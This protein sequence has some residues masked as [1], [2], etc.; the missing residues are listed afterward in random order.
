MSAPADLS[1]RRLR[2]IA[3]L[4]EGVDGDVFKG[5]VEGPLGL[6]RLVLVKRSRRL[7]DFDEEPVEALGREARVYARLDHPCI[8]RLVDFYVDHGRLLLLTTWVE[9]VS[10]EALLEEARA[11]GAPLPR[12]AA[13]HVAAQL[14]SAL[15]AAHGA[16]DPVTREFSP[17]V[18]Q[19][20]SPRTVTVTRDGGVVLGDFERS[21]TLASQELTPSGLLGTHEGYLA[22]EQVQGER[23]SVRADVY[24]ACIVLREM[25]LN[26]PT[27]PH[28]DKDYLEWLDG[29]A[30]PRLRPIR[31]LLPDL[32]ADIAWL[33]DVGLR[34]EPEQRALTASIAA[35]ILAPYGE[36]SA[37]AAR[38]RLHHQA[39]PSSPTDPDRTASHQSLVAARPAPA[40]EVVPPVPPPAP[41]ATST[42]I[43]VTARP[44][45]G[46]TVQGFA[47]R[48]IA[49]RPPRGPRH[50]PAIA[51]TAVLALA[52]GGAAFVIARRPAAV[53]TSGTVASLRPAAAVLGS[54]KVAS[55]SSA[56]A[57]PVVP[58]AA[59]V[60]RLVLGDGHVASVAE[61]LALA[62]ASGLEGR[63]A[64]CFGPE[65]APHN[66]LTLRARCR[67]GA[68]LTVLVVAPIT[69]P[70]RKLAA[71]TEV[72]LDQR[73]WG[74]DPRAF[75][76]SFDTDR[77]F[78]VRHVGTA[79]DNRNPILGPSFGA[80][81]DLGIEPELTRAMAGP[82][83][84]FRVED[85][86]SSVGRFGHVR[87]E[88][89]EVFRRVP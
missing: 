65:D 27:F 56:A 1:R 29:I 59:P 72:P 26:A 16:C 19:S 54:S 71:F 21:R 83:S 66:G 79:V 30:H 61:V 86:A 14:F 88:R 60:P 36:A 58:A 85:Q 20:V 81:H 9:G 77:L 49:T 5:C 6:E 87:V 84:F 15:A 46:P 13:F 76:Y 33:L 48:P 63:F 38:A 37:L 44:T 69:G 7:G 73:G 70:S 67:G 64:R 4:H 45:P 47:L 57:A 82:R 28:D 40:E 25:L 31:S 51:A 41:A 43:A 12:A 78:R 42:R 18:H 3:A 32:D 35:G 10:L 80:G 24:S 34:P 53:A 39:G 52:A 74:K 23:P 17:I 68:T 22:P 75:V 62:Q 50:G 2:R 11:T 55:A 8:P 89:L